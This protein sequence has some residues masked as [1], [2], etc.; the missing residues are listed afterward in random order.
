MLRSMLVGAA[1]LAAIPAVMLSGSPVVA[2]GKDAREAELVGFH[3]LCDK[4]DRKACV[5]FG[6]ML[7]EMK[8]R[9]A[10]WRRL[11]PEFFFWEH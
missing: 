11:H 9:H 7:G 8:E 2:Q 5:R 10:E 4:G 1:V 6:M 3:A